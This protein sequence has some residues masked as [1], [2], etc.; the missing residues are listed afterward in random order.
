MKNKF[1]IG[2]RVI[3]S[4][5]ARKQIPDA[6]KKDFSSRIIIKIEERKYESDLIYLNNA[7][8]FGHYIDSEWLVLDTRLGRILNEE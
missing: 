1:K 2:D 8:A 7:W 3:P 4:L 5:E 6:F